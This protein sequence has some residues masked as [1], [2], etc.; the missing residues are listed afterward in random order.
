M[1]TKKET[2]FQGMDKGQKYSSLR[3]PQGFSLLELM[4]VVSMIAIVA[5]TTILSVVRAR[6]QTQRQNIINNLKKISAAKDQWAMERGKS[7]SDTP[8][9]TDLAP[10]FN[11]NIFPT[12]VASETYFIESISSFPYADLAFPIENE[13]RFTGVN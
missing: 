13:S 6:E 8:Q 4:I 9:T 12:P 10:Y 11:G 7:S 1:P 2:G 3:R 5:S